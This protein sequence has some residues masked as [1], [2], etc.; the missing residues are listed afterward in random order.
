[1]TD[2]S[3]I[4]AAALLLAAGKGKKNGNGAPGPPDTPPGQ[5]KQTTESLT[6]YV[7]RIE[8][9]GDTE[10]IRVHPDYIDEEAGVLLVKP[11]LIYGVD[12]TGTPQDIVDSTSG[13][14]KAGTRPEGTPITVTGTFTKTGGAGTGQTV[15]WPAASDNVFFLG[16]RV[17][18]GGTKATAGQFDVILGD[19]SADFGF[20]ALDDSASTD[21]V[22]SLPSLGEVADAGNNIMDSAIYPIP[23]QSNAAGAGVGYSSL[24]VRCAS[25]ANAETYEV[26]LCFLSRDNTALQTTP[27]G[28]T[29]A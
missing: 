23:M 29:F 3:E 24:N 4:A 26:Y 27:S 2:E 10:R 22:L 25:M 18:T 11:V 1:M 7:Q 12:D 16:G 28:G 15:I 20:L 5:D 14:L 19:L 9:L 8:T 13:Y 6:D 21:I 17:L